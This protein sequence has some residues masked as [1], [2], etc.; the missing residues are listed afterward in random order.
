MTEIGKPLQSWD[1][2]QQP[3]ASFAVVNCDCCHLGMSH[4]HHDD[5]D[6]YDESWSDRSKVRIVWK[7]HSS[8]SAITLMISSSM[9][10]RF[11]KFFS[12][13]LHLIVGFDSD[14]VGEPSRTSE[15]EE[16]HS[17][18]RLLKK[19][20]FLQTPIS[21]V[22]CIVGWSRKYLHWIIW[23]QDAVKNIARQPEYF[24]SLLSVL[25]LIL[26]SG[27]LGTRMAVS[28]LEGARLKDNSSSNSPLCDW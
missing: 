12:G 16:G 23:L 15:V 6:N 8:S 25:W 14:V 9:I 13:Q 2:R 17:L 20:I 5:Y 27:Y 26:S 28:L 10:L 19:K 22:R 18:S 4:D 21:I 7:S 1:D 3:L 24:L 11:T